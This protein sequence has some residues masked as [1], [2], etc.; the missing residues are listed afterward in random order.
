MIATGF[1]PLR[2]PISDRPA[3][4]TAACLDPALCPAPVPRCGAHTTGWRLRVLSR[5]PLTSRTPGARPGF[6]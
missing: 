1:R 2:T 4:A 3:S 6:R 5:P